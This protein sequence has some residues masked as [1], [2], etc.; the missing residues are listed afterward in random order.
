MNLLVT[1]VDDRGNWFRF[2][3]LLAEFL[4]GW[5]TRTRP[6]QRQAS[7]ER[8][9]RWYV[10]AGMLTNAVEHATMLSDRLAPLEIL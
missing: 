7:H 1:P 5:L 4:R 3:P 2:H 8:V 9:A 10:Q 6:D